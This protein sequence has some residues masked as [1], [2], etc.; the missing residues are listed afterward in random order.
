MW[1]KKKKEKALLKTE[2]TGKQASL[3]FLA[4]FQSVFPL[5]EETQQRLS[6]DNRSAQFHKQPCV[7]TI[8]RD[9]GWSYLVTFH[10]L[11]LSSR[12]QAFSFLALPRCE[13]K[14]G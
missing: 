2:Q 7:C 3:T 14:F 9:C 11:Y 4:G 12:V 5:N 6:L 1:G 10:V 13:K 8:G